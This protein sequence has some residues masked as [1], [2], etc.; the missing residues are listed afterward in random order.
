MGESMRLIGE[1]LAKTMDCF[2]QTPLH[3]ASLPFYNQVSRQQLQ[4]QQQ[5]TSSN[6]FDMQPVNA[7]FY[8]EGPNTN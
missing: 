4:S 1:S 2:L 7:A 3:P 8:H 5:G 6:Y